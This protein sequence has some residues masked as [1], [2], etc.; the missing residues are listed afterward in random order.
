M[1]EHAACSTH[2]IY[3]LACDEFDALRDAAGGACQVCTR[4]APLEID[5]DHAVGVNAVRGLVCRSC[6][7]ALRAVDAGTRTP[8]PQERAYLNGAWF[9]RDGFTPIADTKTQTRTFRLPDAV[10]ETAQRTARS[11]GET[12]SAVIRRTLHAFVADADAFEAAC[13]K[14]IGEDQ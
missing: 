9:H 11:Q 10:W 12:V 8:R 1:S 7:L 6:N 4:T 2:G 5:H 14:I 13:L 3:A